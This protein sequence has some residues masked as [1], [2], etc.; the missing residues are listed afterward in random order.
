MA[1][2]T[3][4]REKLAQTLALL[5]RAHG[6]QE[7]TSRGPGLDVFVAMMLAQNTNLTNARAAYRAL[8]RRFPT[9]DEVMRAP[10]RDVQHEIRVCGLARMRARRLQ[11]LLTT[12]HSEEG[13]LDLD[14]LRD[15]EPAAAY[16]YLTHFFGIGPK[17]ATCTLLFAFGM[18][19]FPVDKQIQRVA[20]RMGLARPRA[21]ESVIARALE[22]LIDPKD[23]YA[24]HVLMHSHGRQFCRPRNPKCKECALVEICKYGRRRLKH[25]PPPEEM[26]PLRL[27]PRALSRRASDGLK[28]NAD[29]ERRAR[30]KELP[31]MS[32]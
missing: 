31:H 17:T 18:P 1:N 4:A 23:R 24:A 30:R 8:R 6:P 2:P 21:G 10:V 3:Q 7:W 5:R 20:W 12:L 19:V 16:E 27:R 25:Q 22:P 32:S 14:F 29:A 9:W 26:K 28:K 11:K 13:A 15:W